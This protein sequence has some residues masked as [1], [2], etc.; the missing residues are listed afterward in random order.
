MQTKE[1][2]NLQA[3]LRRK[4]NYH[5]IP[6]QKGVMLEKDTKENERI[7]FTIRPE[8]CNNPSGITMYTVGKEYAE[9]LHCSI[10]IEEL[11]IIVQIYDELTK[12]YRNEFTI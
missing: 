10:N 1:R 5:S 9:C 3:K 6:L 12:E 8:Q 4:Y 11:R 7:R 2:K